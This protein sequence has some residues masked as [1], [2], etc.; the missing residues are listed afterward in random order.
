M[1]LVLNAAQ[2]MNG[3]GT[4]T[5]RTRPDSDGVEFDLED[6]GCGIAE[7]NLSRIFEPFFTTKEQ[8]EGTGLG[9]SVAYGI[10]SQHG[11]R[12]DV[13][14]RV[15]V[16]TTFTVRLPAGPAAPEEGGT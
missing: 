7:E 4:L 2:A 5:F 3:R 15:G 14:S 1:N 13:R 10:V 12:I 6:T 9:L 16:G 11:G 8:G